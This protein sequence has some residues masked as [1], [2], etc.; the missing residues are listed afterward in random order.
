MAA[1]IGDYLALAVIL[2]VMLAMSLDTVTGGLLM[3]T[4]V[5]YC[6]PAF[7]S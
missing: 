4:L 2:A 5:A 3:L 7:L 1:L 6:M